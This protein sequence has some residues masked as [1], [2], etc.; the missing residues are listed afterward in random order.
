MLKVSIDERLDEDKLKP[1]IYGFMFIQLLHMIHVVKMACPTVA[2]LICKYD[3]DLAYQL[4]HMNGS[5]AARFL[6]ITTLCALFYLG[7]L[8]VRQNGVSLSRSLLNFPAIYQTNHSGITTF[9]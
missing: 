6:C 9:T 3:F 2:I 1:L 8:Q 5:S 7:L 4:M